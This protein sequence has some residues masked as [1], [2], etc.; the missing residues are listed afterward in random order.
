MMIGTL[1]PEASFSEKA[2]LKWDSFAEIKYYDD[3]YDTI[4]AFLKH[5]VEYSIVPIENSLEGSVSVTLDMLME[6]ELKIIGEIILKIE[7]CL[8]SKG[9][10]KDIKTILSHPQAL[11][12]SRKFIKQNFKNI[13]IKSS[14]STSHAAK[15]ASKNKN[16]AAVASREAA[17]RYGLNILAEN[18]QD[19]KDNFT[20]FVV[21][22]NETPSP[23]NND[24]TSIILYLEK[25]HPGALYNIL[26]EFS[27]KKIDLTKIESRPT[28]KTLGDYLFYID[29]RGHIEDKNIRETLEKIKKKSG[30]LKIIGSYPIATNL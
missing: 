28:K 30:M 17:Y 19:M 10:K 8:L 25:N 24:K 6:H 22:G 14:M 13:E 1:G 11:S 12:Q 7:H 16:I 4:D 18:I 29:F 3:I 26:G 9:N 5:E 15:I 23:T 21:I 2:T 20:R 27:S